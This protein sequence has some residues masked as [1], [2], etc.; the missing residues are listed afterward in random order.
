MAKLRAKDILALMIFGCLVCL[1]GLG[2]VSTLP[3]KGAYLIEKMDS[4]VALLVTGASLLFPLLGL[5]FLIAKQVDRAERFQ[6]LSG[7][8]VSLVP[9]VCILWTFLS[10]RLAPLP[11]HV[12]EG[13][14]KRVVAGMTEAQVVQA[15]GLPRG[16]SWGDHK[17]RLT[18]DFQIAWGLSGRQFFVDLVDNR[19]VS[20]K[21]VRYGGEVD[22]EFFQSDFL[23]ELKK[24]KVI[25]VEPDGAANRSQPFSSDTNRTS[26]ASAAPVGIASC[27][28]VE[29]VYHDGWR[30][31]GEISLF[32]N[33]H[34]SWRV[35]DVSST[36]PKSQTFSGALPDS[37]LQPLS[38]GSSSF[39]I[40]AGI[41]T[42]E[43]NID[44]SKTQHPA[45]VDALRT[46]LHSTHWAKK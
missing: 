22:D 23:K 43:L 26:S 30:T 11:Y 8:V 41:R 20:A 5:R 29:R 33:G 2:F 38:A 45:G 4:G 17:K 12:C 34:Y 32:S 13:G 21:I 15:L 27:R 42:Y 25:K 6:L 46:Y 44:D 35:S 16:S 39:E 7:F 14:T 1:L 18:Y 37:I 9:T 36:P 24:G 10:A 3:P 28:I 31:C 19:V 40:R